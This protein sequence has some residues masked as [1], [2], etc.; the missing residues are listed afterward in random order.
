MHVC[1]F[2]L[3]YGNIDSTSIHY[4]SSVTTFQVPL[5]AAYAPE[6]L[7]SFLTTSQHYPLEAAYEVRTPGVSRN[8]L[9]LI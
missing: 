2:P 9:T 5:Y 6:C 3:L 8:A 4:S 7:M 1:L